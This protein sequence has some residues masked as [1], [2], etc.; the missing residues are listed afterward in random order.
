MSGRKRTR[1][2]AFNSAFHAVFRDR[3]RLVVTMEDESEPDR[4]YRLVMG[5]EDAVRL[6]S[7]LALQLGYKLV[8][9]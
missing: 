8:Q 1:A 4:P 6:A 9:S 2:L 5:D 3:D 7:R